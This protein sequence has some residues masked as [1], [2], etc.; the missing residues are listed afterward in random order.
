MNKEFNCTF[1]INCDVPCDHRVYRKQ[2]PQTESWFVSLP[3]SQ[4]MY[5]VY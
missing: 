3:K 5:S 2:T 4:I 1:T